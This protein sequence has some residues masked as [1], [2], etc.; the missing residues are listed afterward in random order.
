MSLATNEYK[1]LMSTKINTYAY[2]SVLK[3]LFSL[4]LS[5]YLDA[6]FLHLGVIDIQMPA[7]VFYFE[8]LTR[9][10]ILSHIYIYMVIKI[11][12]ITITYPNENYS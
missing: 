8:H 5:R 11:N 6:T 2:H 3:T 10:Y 9:I 4:N 12:T 1:Y 7:K